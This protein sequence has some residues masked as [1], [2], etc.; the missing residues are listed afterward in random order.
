[1]SDQPHKFRYLLPPGNN[2]QFVRKFRIWMIFSLLFMAG[3]VAM[4]VFVNPAIRGGYMNW[5]IDF[6]G[7]TEIVV[8]FKEKANDTFKQVD[9]AKVREALD[10][11]K[12]EGV[13]VSEIEWRDSND[14]PIQ[15]MVIRTPKFSAISDAVK[16][17]ARAAFVERFKDRNIARATWS[18]DRFNVRST[19]PIPDTEAAAFFKTLD[20]D[21]KPLV[22]KPWSEAEKES[23]TTPDATTKE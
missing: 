6:K 11:A 9:P 14:K 2:F 8:A 10:K 13:D 21:G 23:Y 17:K 1:M 15:G 5:T 7:G 19:V 18:G 4:V 3:S 12:E 20:N 16:E 22:A